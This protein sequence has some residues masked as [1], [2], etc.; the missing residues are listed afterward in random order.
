VA[1]REGSEKRRMEI[2]HEGGQGSSRTAIGYRYRYT[3]GLRITNTISKK[4]IRRMFYIVARE[5][6]CT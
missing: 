1:E 6:L 2:C 3:A 4:Y 5:N